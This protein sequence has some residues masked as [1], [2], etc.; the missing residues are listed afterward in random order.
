MRLSSLLAAAGVATIC[1]LAFIQRT[2]PLHAA[3]DDRRVGAGR[4]A[5]QFE[6]KG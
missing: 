2:Q 4:V 6:T 1:V 5:W 3:A